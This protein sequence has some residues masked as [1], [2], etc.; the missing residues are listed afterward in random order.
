MFGNFI[1]LLCFVLMGSTPNQVRA[2]GNQESIDITGRVPSQSPG[3][4]LA[5]VVPI[6]WDAR[7]LPVQYRLNETLDPIPNPFGPPT[8]SISQALP[9][10]QQALD[11]WNDIPT[12]FID[13]RIIGSTSNPGDSGLDT[14]NEVT[15][16]T[17]L[18]EPGLLALSV[19]FHTIEDTVFLDGED[20]DGD[21]DPDFSSAI[22]ACADVD[23]DG[24]IEFPAG[25]YKAGTIFD[26]DVIFFSHAWRFSGGS[27]D[28]DP[29]SV[30]LMAVAVHE[31]GHSHGLTHSLT[32]Q[33]SATDGRAAVMFP[34]FD[35]ADPQHELSQRTL[36][37]EEIAWSSFMY[38][39]GSATVGPAALA[40]EDVAFEAVFGLIR[41]EARHGILKEGI[42]GANIFA[43]GKDSHGVD[44]IA[45][46]GFSGTLRFHVDPVA[47]TLEFV[48]SLNGNF[49][50]PAPR[51]EFKVGIEPL[52]E[53][54]AVGSSFNLTADI[55]PLFGG[56]DFDEEFLT[57]GR[58]VRTVEV[59][60]GKSANRVKIVTSRTIRIDNFGTLDSV[61]FTAASPGTY[62]AVRI[63]ADQIMATV[64]RGRFRIESADF[65]TFPSDSSVVPIFSEALLT[66]GTVNADG[67]ASIDLAQPLHRATNFVGQ[68]TDFARLMFND[69]AQLGAKI[70]RA[71]NGRE[72]Q[73]LFLVL[74]VPT[75]I[76]FAGNSGLPPL[77]GLDGDPAGNDVPIFGLSY[78]SSDG[79][80]TFRPRMDFNFMFR[81]VISE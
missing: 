28:G 53:F 42:V 20:L 32:N 46:S 47:G 75:T 60:P 44:T 31:F 58:R 61:G 70:R 1:V 8:L 62:Y 64:P 45:S 38:P 22:S 4:I 48:E 17:S 67:T 57:R 71:I 73:N 78:V 21:G 65:M 40:P 50:V 68:D 6:R 15:F 25:L 18:R 41:G 14:S 23:Q 59:K 69:A 9:V 13:M 26:N 63:P 39:E 80:I 7:C 34:T 49:V 30:D 66:T 74:R 76:P 56:H 2:G 72:I 3:L 55:G 51:G 43:V 19:S 27:P 35:S 12:S 54:P 5:D 33:L 79:G 36:T 11:V 52:D 37:T 77:I 24:D 16:R 81:L 10:L 29:E